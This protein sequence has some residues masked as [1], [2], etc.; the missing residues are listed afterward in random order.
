MRFYF[1]LYVNFNYISQMDVIFAKTVLV[2][3]LIASN[4]DSLSHKVGNPDIGGIVKA[5]LC[6]S[7]NIL[8]LCLKRC[9]FFLFF[10][11]TKL[12]LTV[13]I[14]RYRFTRK[15]LVQP[16]FTGSKKLHDR[17][18]ILKWRYIGSNSLCSVRCEWCKCKLKFF[19]AVLMSLFK[20]WPFYHS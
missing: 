10:M 20:R 18:Q 9:F 16:I 5:M 1:H 11:K 14:L 12:I 7:L 17:L 19:H 2:I 4:T 3:L 6:F 15:K 13:C 8:L